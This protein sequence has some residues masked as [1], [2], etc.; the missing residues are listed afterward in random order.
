MDNFLARCG[1]C[2]TETGDTMLLIGC[3]SF[4]LGN[5][6][7]WIIVTIIAI[8]GVIFLP[9]FIVAVIISSIHHNKLCPGDKLFSGCV[10]GYSI[11]FT[12]GVFTPIII[13]VIIVIVCVL[14]CLTCGSFL[15]EY[16][17]QR[18]EKREQQISV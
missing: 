13:L 8:G 3:I 16:A 15:T 12:W 4:L 5:G 7:F 17:E 14:L 18:K 10:W 2:L 6:V 1:S 9:P 11:L